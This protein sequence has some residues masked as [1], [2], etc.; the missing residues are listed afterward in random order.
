LT[1]GGELQH[2][3]FFYADPDEFLAGTVPF[4]R[5]GLEAEEAVMVALPPSNR[6]LLRGELGADATLVKFTEIEELGRN[7]ARLTSAWSDFLFT[8]GEV[9]VRGLGEPVWPGRSEAE[10]E[11]CRR[12][13]ALLNRISGDASSAS[14]LCPYDAARLDDAV[15]LAAEHT[16][17]AVSGR[18]RSERYEAG[19]DVFAGRLGRPRGEL[20]ETVF[21]FDAAGLHSVRRLVFAEAARTDLE[22]SRAGD[23]VLAASEV[24]SN[25]IRHGGGVGVLQIWRRRE[26]IV[27]EFRDSGR[28]ADPLVGRVRPGFDRLEGRGLWVA[29]QVCDLVQIRWEGE[30]VVRLRMSAP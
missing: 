23:L 5:G 25:S 10:L 2:E 6:E 18:Q 20:I 13:E 9:G 21:A 22:T 8:N 4:V 12:H 29:Q 26:E 3:A 17:P 28:I 15:L 27:C 14:L 19:A 11:E 1:E 30:N 16:H 7:P 24:A